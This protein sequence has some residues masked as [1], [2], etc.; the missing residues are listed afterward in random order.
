MTDTANPAP[1][2][3]ADDMDA[4]TRELTASIAAGTAPAGRLLGLPE[5]PDDGAWVD[6]AGAAAVTGYPAKTI[7]GW[8]SR[9][10][11]KGNPFPGPLRILYRL[12]WPL[13]EIETWRDTRRA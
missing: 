11:P 2:S 13:A 7:T 3:V 6:I 4:R 8:L 5:L 9:G 10:Y 12:Y 1:A